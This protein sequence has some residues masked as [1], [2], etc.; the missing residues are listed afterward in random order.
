MLR[1][2]VACG[3]A[4]LLTL[5][6]PPTGGAEIA[7]RVQTPL[8]SS[9]NSVDAYAAF[10]TEASHRFAI[11]ERWVHAVIQVESDWNARATSPKGALGL[12]QI[13]PQTWVD[14][15][16]RYDLGV[17]PF[18]VRD[19]ITA[20]TAYLRQ[21]LDRFGTEGFLAAYNAGPKRYEEHL[22]AGRPLP[23]ET[24]AYVAQVASLIGLEQRVRVTAVA[25]H[26]VAW[27]QAPIFV[28]RPGSSSAGR[29]SASDVHSMEAP[30]DTPTAAQSALAPHPTGVFVQR[31][32]EAQSR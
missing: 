13:M 2:T 26:I 28:Q 1:G 5:G 27:Q 16:A 10:I 4:V 11:P 8:S 23:E 14:L 19:N 21:M 29:K 20:G 32:N 12:M 9:S 7:R 3:L 15:S 30:N 6:T 17:D 18:D 31:L 24:Q 25:R 22:A